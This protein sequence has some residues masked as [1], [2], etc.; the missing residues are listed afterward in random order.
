MTTTAGTV[1]AGE[2]FRRIDSLLPTH[3][4]QLLAW[5]KDSRGFS[6]CSRI[7][8]KREGGRRDGREARESWSSGICVWREGLT[9]KRPAYALSLLG[10]LAGVRKR[11]Y[12]QELLRGS[13]EASA[14]SC[15]PFAGESDDTMT[16]N[17]ATR[18]GSTGDSRISGGE[19]SKDQ[20]CR[21]GWRG[22]LSSPTEQKSTVPLAPISNPTG[23]F[24]ERVLG[25]VLP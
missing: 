4:P 11:S 5:H 21:W 2:E 22:A 6:S 1:L 16:E 10:L 9:D 13:T 14:F 18:R 24:F 8:V 7:E 25:A 20:I 12:M 3:H 17:L 23:G 19:S 15:T